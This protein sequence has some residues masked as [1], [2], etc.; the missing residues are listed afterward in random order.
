MTNPKN[1]GRPKNESKAPPRVSKTYTARKADLTN[2][3]STIYASGS[4]IVRKNVNETRFTLPC[5]QN[6]VN[7]EVETYRRQMEIHDRVMKCI[8]PR[9]NNEVKVEFL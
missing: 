5:N 1:C 9:N 7:I 2:S 4:P 3:M 6:N 8:S